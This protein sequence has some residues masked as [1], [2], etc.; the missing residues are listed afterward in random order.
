MI[1]HHFVKNSLYLSSKGAYYG[2]I[3][4]FTTNIYLILG[5]RKTKMECKPWKKEK[6]NKRK[7]N[8]R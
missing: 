1:I 5:E 4:N 7:R 3:K 2:K 6:E 8:S